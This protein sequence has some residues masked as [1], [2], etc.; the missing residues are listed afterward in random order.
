M[1]VVAVIPHK[2]LSTQSLDNGITTETSANVEVFYIND[3][4]RL[5]D[6][7]HETLHMGIL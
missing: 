4:L 1:K 3:L 5:Q 7:H 2:G 6:Y